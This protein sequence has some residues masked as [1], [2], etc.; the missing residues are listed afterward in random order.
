MRNSL[1][2]SIFLSIACIAYAEFY[3]SFGPIVGRTIEE[4]EAHAGAQCR[5]ICKPHLGWSG[6]Y[7]C[8]EKALVDTRGTLH[9]QV[10]GCLCECNDT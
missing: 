3:P 4:R 8:S 1:L 5:A 6:K 9:Y 7:Q 10:F 2:L